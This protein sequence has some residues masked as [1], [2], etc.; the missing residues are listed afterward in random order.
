MPPEPEVPANLPP[1][2]STRPDLAPLYAHM[3]AE[4]SALR[5][6]VATLKRK[7]D[8]ALANLEAVTMRVK[9]LCS[10][11]TAQRI[12]AGT[13]A[14]WTTEGALSGFLEGVVEGLMTGENSCEDSEQ[15]S[16]GAFQRKL[17]ALESKLDTQLRKSEHTLTSLLGKLS[18]DRDIFTSALDQ[19]RS[20]RSHTI[21]PRN[22]YD[23][24]QSLL[25][26]V[27]SLSAYETLKQSALRYD[28]FTMEKVF[29]YASEAVCEAEASVLELVHELVVPLPMLELVEARVSRRIDLVSELPSA[30]S[31][32]H[33]LALLPQYQSLFRQLTKEDYEVSP[34]VCDV[35]TIAHKVGQLASDSQRT[36]TQ[37]AQS[38]ILESRVHALQSALLMAKASLVATEAGT[39][40]YVNRLFQ[41]LR[42]QEGVKLDLLKKSREEL[43]EEEEKHAK[44]A[45]EL[46]SLA[47]EY[48]SLVSQIARFSSKP[49]ASLVEMVPYLPENEQEIVRFSSE[50]RRK[51]AEMLEN[52]VGLAE[53]E[54]D[55]LL[56]LLNA[57]E[58]ALKRKDASES[59]EGRQCRK[60]K[61]HI[62][63]G[64]S[65]G[66]T[67]TKRIVPWG[68]TK[69][70]LVG[71]LH[72][73]ANDRSAQ[74]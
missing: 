13:T 46:Q 26:K 15:D 30:E 51:C 35:I 71:A 9:T 44:T 39:I 43:A 19:V 20:H 23:F 69:E 11:Q 42:D 70:V 28:L 17:A 52:S 4:K 37:L 40:E 24:L 61:R 72:L 31:I 48:L 41:L 36:L 63:E 8:T 33:L 5:R 66:R 53:P 16:V 65:M 68:P 38:D 57:A 3:K 62:E 21:I 25:R 60:V 67:Q 10:A 49:D 45:T 27:D 2:A 54:S 73:L 34:S 14:D 58:E 6:E 56:E 22:D 7:L 29:T 18:L 50:V 59:E 74:R 12:L 47:M 55:F 32:E 1:P 64:R